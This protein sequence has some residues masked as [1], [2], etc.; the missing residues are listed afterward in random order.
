MS[1]KR[2]K[3]VGAVVRKSGVSFRVWAPFAE[4]VAVT[5]SFNDWSEHPL[6]NELD[7]YWWAEIS[8]AKPGQEY[9]FAIKNGQETYF[10][11]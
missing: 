11:K 9:K 3:E 8:G 2:K 1:G 10:S 4:S 7:G 6:E 5:G